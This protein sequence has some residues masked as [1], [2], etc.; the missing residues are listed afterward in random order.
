MIKKINKLTLNS[1]LVYYYK[2]IAMV[3][4]LAIF[5]YFYINQSESNVSP[6]NKCTLK[7][8]S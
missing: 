5:I 8:N 7:V 4:V 2:Y 6:L 1:T 3:N